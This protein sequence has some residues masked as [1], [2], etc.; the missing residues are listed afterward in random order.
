MGSRG[1]AAP[2]ELTDTMRTAAAPE[3]GSHASPP[4]VDARDHMRLFTAL[5]RELRYLA[6]RELRRSSAAALSPT[7]L[8]HETY[9][10]ISGREYLAFRSGAE[11]M[12]YASRAMRGLLIDYLRGRQTQKRGGE[13]QI[14]P[15]QTEL[16]HAV[17]DDDVEVLRV[18]RLN[19]ALESL[20]QLDPR[21]AECVDMRF[22]CGLSFDEI[23]KLRGVSKRTAQRDWDK[24]RVLLNRLMNGDAAG[25]Q[26]EA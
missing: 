24:A 26:S 6:Q 19:E 17:T 15:L 20:A 23:A 1:A 21:L 16:L 3:S 2:M 14:L 25:W 11:F 9:L 8:L 10:N 7:T 18:E 13:L 22:F 5:Y 4:E 12:A